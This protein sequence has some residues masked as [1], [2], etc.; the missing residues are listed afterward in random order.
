MWDYSLVGEG[1]QPLGIED[2]VSGSR[3]EVVAHLDSVASA[4]VEAGTCRSVRVNVDG[5]DEGGY[6]AS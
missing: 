2:C 1:G 3:A 4:L 6:S 5:E